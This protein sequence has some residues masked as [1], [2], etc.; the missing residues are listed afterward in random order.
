MVAAVFILEMAMDS[1][2][3]IPRNFITEIIDADLKKGRHN[4]VATR[5]PPEPTVIC[6]SV[7]AEAFCLNFGLHV[8]TTAPVTYVLMTPIC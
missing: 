2:E 7:T 1:V 5:F 4:H 8:I 6:T 3:K